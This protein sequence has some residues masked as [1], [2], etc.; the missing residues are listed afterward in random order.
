MV[1]CHYLVCWLCATPNTSHLVTHFH[2]VTYR[3]KELTFGT[4]VI[5]L[6]HPTLLTDL[7][8]IRF[9]CNEYYH[10]ETEASRFDPCFKDA[11]DPEQSGFLA[12][13]VCQTWELTQTLAS[14]HSPERFTVSGVAYHRGDIIRVKIQDQPLASILYIRKIEAPDLILCN[15]FVRRASRSPIGMNLEE[16][17]GEVGCS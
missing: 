9:L 10:P 16:N 13:P 5:H 17:G 8:C 7:I 2:L 6:T 3:H 4:G 1:M 12:C 11:N 14:H 15:F